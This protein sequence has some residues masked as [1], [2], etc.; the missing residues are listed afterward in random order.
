MNGVTLPVPP[1]GTILIKNESLEP[2]TVYGAVEPLVMEPDASIV[3]E[4]TE[5]GWKVSPA[6]DAL[7]RFYIQA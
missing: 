5:R 3:F 4:A 7:E 1:S 2:L 6:L